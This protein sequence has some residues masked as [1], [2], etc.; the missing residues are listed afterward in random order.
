MAKNQTI[1]AWGEKIAEN[2]FVEK[3]Y[4]IIGKNI[5]TPYG[6]LDLVISKEEE[7]IFV[8]VKTRTTDKFG[9]PEDAVSKIKRSHLIQ[10][11]EAYMQIHEEIKKD[12]RIDVVA[13]QG[14]PGMEK[15]LIEWFENAT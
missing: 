10:S 15:F 5:R 9:F 14:R 3:G 1:G 7:I 11:A 2:F 4:V 12:W 6:E 13:I 8:E